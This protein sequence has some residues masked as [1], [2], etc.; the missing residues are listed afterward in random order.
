MIL[1]FIIPMYNAEE[2]IEQCL[3]SIIDQPVNKNIFEIILINDGSTDNSLSK[4]NEISKKHKSITVYSQ[5]NKGLSAT[6]NRGIELARGAYIWFIDADD[7]IIPNTVNTLL[8]CLKKHN[9]DILEFQ[10]IRTE[11]RVLNVSINNNP[12]LADVKVQNGKKYVAR[13]GYNESCCISIYRRELII[14]IGVRFIEGKIMEDMVFNAE[15]VPKANRIAYYPLD[16]YRYVINPN[17]IWMNEESAAYRKSITDFI[18]MTKK[19][20]FFIKDY[21]QNDIGTKIIESKQQEMLFN[22]SKRLLTSDFTISEINTIIKD[23]RKHKLYPLSKYNGISKFRKFENY[24]F[25]KKLLF[26][27]SIRIYRFFKKPIDHFIIKKY[28]QRREKLIKET[29]VNP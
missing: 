27:L 19:I 1:S 17:S 4:A 20:S 21:K 9:L 23:L 18:F 5:K 26:L 11:S 28:R 16:A 6:R 22:I 25:N 15:I 2:Y 29:I 12:S 14:Q 8:S 10:Y 7:Y 13:R 3:Y 24:M